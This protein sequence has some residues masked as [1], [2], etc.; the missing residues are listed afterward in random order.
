MKSP[1]TWV[2]ASGIAAIAAAGCAD[3]ITDISVSS[4]EPDLAAPLLNTTFTLH[5][6]I[7]GT[8]FASNLSEDE[9]SGL[10]IS[11][12]QELFDVRP[13]E[14][15]S[16]PNILIP[17]L[18]S[19]TVYELTDEELEVGLNK[20]DFTD[21]GLSITFTNTLSESVLVVVES[22]SFEVNGAPLRHE[23]LVGAESTASDTIAL[24]GIRVDFG[25]DSEV[26]ITYQARTADGTPVRFPAGAIGL[27]ENE[28]SYAEGTLRELAVDLGQDSIAFKALNAFNRGEVEL[29]DV[30]ARFTFTNEIG[31]PF[32]FVT[33]EAYATG[34]DGESIAFESSFSRG[35]E[36]AYP[37]LSEGKVAKTTEIV[38]N[39]ETSNF[40]DVIN[41]LPTRVV[42]GLAAQANP[43]GL[44]DRFFIH[45]DARLTGRF[46]LD[47]PLALRFN[48]F[49]LE[50]EF[51]F[52]GDSFRDA[53]AAALRLTVEN[54]FGLA[55]KVQ[56]FFEDEDGG[57][58]DS[59]FLQPTTIVEAAEVDDYGATVSASTRTTEVELTGAQ[60]ERLAG[61]TQALAVIRLS[62]PQDGAGIT[63]LFY[64]NEISF[65]I[66]ARVTVK[67]F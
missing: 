66:G 30:D 39:S 47:L 51:A 41:Q 10:R 6:A 24:A 37:A 33:P 45:D 46:D 3:P 7:G 40:V 61:S 28:F 36:V 8:E 62:S 19:V 15:F 65:K 67:P 13:A 48:D 4:F 54:E 14:N 38:V 21:G 43:A 23:M 9:D 44:D 50:Q 31:V 64:D 56:V 27:V 35:V 2:V 11:I 52:D 26:L 34:P 17:V 29:V 60:I 55:A 12:S 1:S 53:E 63:R 16:L 20:V 32:S 25:D 58:V 22:E 57:T 59:L 18:D 49:A 5:D 42:I